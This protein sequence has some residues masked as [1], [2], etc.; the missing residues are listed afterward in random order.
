MTIKLRKSDALYIYL[1]S[2]ASTEEKN[3]SLVSEY[4]VSATET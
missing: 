3:L 4:R 2:F 1:E